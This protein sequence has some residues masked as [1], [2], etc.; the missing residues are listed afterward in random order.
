MLVQLAGLNNSL[1]QIAEL[2]DMG[3]ANMRRKSLLIRSGLSKFERFLGFVLHGLQ[4]AG[5]IAVGFLIWNFDALTGHHWIED[6]T[7]EMSHHLIL[8][9]IIGLLIVG[10]WLVTRLKNLVSIDDPP[11]F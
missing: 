9:F 3:L 5:I 11:D 2:R 7:T 8:T 6:L 4:I 1:D 10:L